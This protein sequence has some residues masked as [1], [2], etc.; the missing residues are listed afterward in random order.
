[1][2]KR[3]SWSQL[4]RGVSTVL[5]SAGCAAIGL[6]A[7]IGIHDAINQRR[8][9]EFMASKPAITQQYVIASL[10]SHSQFS[11]GQ[12]AKASE[13]QSRTSAIDEIVTTAFK[14]DYGIIAVTDHNNDDFYT[15]LEQRATISMPSLGYDVAQL[16][17]H[18]LKAIER[19]DHDSDGKQ[20][21]LYLL[22]GCEITTADT[23]EV[24]GIGY[25]KLPASYR[26][27]EETLAALKEQDALIIAPHPAFLVFDGGGMGEAALKK[28]A[29]L[30]DAVEV[31]G[32]IPFPAGCFFNGLARKWAN[33]CGLPV[34]ATTDA[35]FLEQYFNTYATLFS[36]DSFNEHAIVGY[37][38][39][40][41]RRSNFRRVELI[42]HSFRLYDW[43]AQ[44][45]R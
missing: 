44:S 41:L 43:Y 17:G 15:T 5:L 30:I 33:E 24:I 28:N 40:C 29:H 23:S 2:T 20:D 7:A 37:L 4:K 35:H 13:N 36:S 34:I 25:Q 10:H 26:P 21:V 42:P 27:L 32:S 6:A 8:V 19:D 22:K 39:E 11:D 12:S 16:N 14:N 9:Q 1:M 18:T 45:L 38:K 31:N 3:D